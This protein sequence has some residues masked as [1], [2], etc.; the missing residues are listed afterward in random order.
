MNLARVLALQGET[1][2]ARDLLNAALAQDAQNVDA[3][4]AMA[5]VHF[6]LGENQRAI[7]NYQQALSLEQTELAWNGLAELYMNLGEAEKALD[8][9]KRSLEVNPTQ[10][11]V[12]RKM[13][14]LQ[15]REDEE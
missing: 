12:T 7:E 2:I 15:G 11:Q 9:L 6:R 13:K 4:L 5:Y 3:L 8:C 1:K 10:P 14:E